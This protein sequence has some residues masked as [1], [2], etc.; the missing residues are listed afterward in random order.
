MK[1]FGATRTNGPRLSDDAGLPDFPG[2]TIGE[3][4]G[5]DLEEVS[6]KTRRKRPLAERYIRP[7]ANPLSLRLQ[8]PR[9]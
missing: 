6:G 5:M 4:Y 7:V 9:A 3:L 8:C 2:C 1:S